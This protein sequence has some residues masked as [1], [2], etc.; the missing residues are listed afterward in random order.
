M[1]GPP[2][3]APHVL[4]AA[5]E[6]KRLSPNKDKQISDLNLNT[7]DFHQWME[8][9]AEVVDDFKADTKRKHGARSKVAEKK[10]IFLMFSDNRRLSNELK[11]SS[12]KVMAIILCRFIT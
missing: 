11:G 1:K 4:L 6:K 7:S 10:N 12:L 3:C 5:P 2:L 9:R 8:A